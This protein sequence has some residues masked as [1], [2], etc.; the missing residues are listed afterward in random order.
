MRSVR[1]YNYLA[2]LL[3]ASHVVMK[4]LTSF[5]PGARAAARPGGEGEPAVE[6]RD[7]PKQGQR[8]KNGGTVPSP[9][10]YL[11]PDP[12]ALLAQL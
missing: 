5:L 4:D 3:A 2:G 8:G 11:R 6:Q 7:E 10:N 1:P 9:S 12:H